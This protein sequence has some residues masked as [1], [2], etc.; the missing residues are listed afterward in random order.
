MA[1]GARILRKEKSPPLPDSLRMT[2]IGRSTQVSASS[3]PKEPD[4]RVL[5]TRQLLVQAFIALL[6]EKGFQSLT[7]Q[8]I[9]ERATVNRATFYAHFEDKYALLNSTIR[10]HFQQLLNSRISASCE[11]NQENFKSF[12][13]AAFEFLEQFHGKCARRTGQFEPLIEAQVQVLLC[14][15]LL[16]WFKQP[17]SAKLIR[18]EDLEIAATTISWAIFGAA[19]EWARGDK[20]VSAEETAGKVL[21]LVSRGLRLR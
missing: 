15:F 7:V 17:N 2:L 6:S 13:L 5:R 18:T 19:L 4:P 16:T 1:A 8:D 10:E 21:V 11:I 12:I 20:R 3:S 9:A 14:E